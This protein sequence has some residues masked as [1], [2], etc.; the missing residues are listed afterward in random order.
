[1]KANRTALFVLVVLVLAALACS[2]AA[3]ETK[4]IVVTSPPVVVTR[5]VQPTARPATARPRPTI[6]PLH[7]Q[8][9]RLAAASA[10]SDNGFSL[11][12][13]LK[14][15]DESCGN[16]L[17]LVY[18][19]PAIETIIIF[20][21]ENDE[22]SSV[23]FFLGLDG[24]TTEQTIAML[25]VAQASGVSGRAIDAAIDLESGETTAIGNWF[26]TYEGDSDGLYFLFIDSRTI[27]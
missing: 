17:C 24:D 10:L 2:T 23:S 9:P 22:L 15:S 6:T 11:I 19:N 18:M 13:T 4:T 1:M 14:K 7:V 12:D 20:R 21:I 8:T 16:D 25:A 3:Q 27:E 5:I 26:V